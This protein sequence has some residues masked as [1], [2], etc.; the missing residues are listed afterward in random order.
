MWQ[1][2]DIPTT[3]VS[4]LGLNKRSVSDFRSATP[5]WEKSGTGR[6]AELQS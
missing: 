3:S 2:L 5:L 6:L 1:L 4:M